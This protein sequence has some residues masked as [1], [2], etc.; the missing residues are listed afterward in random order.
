MVKF[1][2]LLKTDLFAELLSQIHFL[3]SGFLT[4]MGLLTWS[5]F[6]LHFFLIHKGYKLTVIHIMETSWYMYFYNLIA[7]EKKTHADQSILPYIFL[8]ACSVYAFSC[9]QGPELFV[10]IIAT[11]N[12]KK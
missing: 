7:F 11:G 2:E 10:Q 12:V 1:I 3:K 4:F 8:L 6:K 5:T 9:L